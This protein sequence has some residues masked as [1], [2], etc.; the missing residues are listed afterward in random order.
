M[1]SNTHF[2][3]F[4]S[5]NTTPGYTGL[6][7]DLTTTQIVPELEGKLGLHYMRSFNSGSIMQLELGYLFSTYLNGIKQVVP[8]ALVPNAFNQGVIAIETSSQVQSNLDMNGPYLK[9]TYLFT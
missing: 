2:L 3:S 9:L 7:N 8:T 4:G 6:A 5:G 1:E